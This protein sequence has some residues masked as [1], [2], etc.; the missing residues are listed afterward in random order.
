[1]WPGS[2]QQRTGS[3][4][5]VRVRTPRADGHVI[6]V[7]DSADQQASWFDAHVRRHLSAGAPEPTVEPVHR[8]L[9]ATGTC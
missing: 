4:R 1:M 2:R 5:I 9:L 7:W 3:S 8:G 6:E